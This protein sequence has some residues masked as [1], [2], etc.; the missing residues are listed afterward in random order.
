M[1]RFAI[2][3][4][5]LFCLAGISLAQSE[6]VSHSTVPAA[7]VSTTTPA[8]VA[9]DVAPAASSA[10]TTK[11]PKT[12]WWNR[13]T[14]AS[15]T[16]AKA[17]AGSDVRA[18]RMTRPGDEDRL[19]VADSLTPYNGP[20]LD[21]RAVTPVRTPPLRDIV[22]IPPPKLG[23]EEAGE[24]HREPMIPNPP[25]IKGGPD[26]F[27]QTAPGPLISAP[28]LTG[29]NF[30]GIGVGL[31]AFTPNSNPPDTNGRVG[32]TQYVQWNNTSFAVF[33]KTTGALLFGPV[34]GNT[35][36]QTLGGVCASHNDGD[37]TVAYDLLSGRWILAQFVVQAPAGTASHECVAISATSDATGSYYVY[38]FLTDPTNFVDYPKIGV[39]PDGYYMTGHVFNAA[40]TSLV[41]ARVYA[42]ERSQMIQGLPARQ[43]SADLPTNGG[44]VQYGFLPADLDSLTP[45]PAGEA[46]FIL[47]PGNLTNQTASTRVA[48]TWGATPTMTLTSA[49]ITTVGITVA[50]CVGSA[51]ARRCA[52]QP[53]PAVSTDAVDNLRSHYMYRLAYRNFGGSPVQE[54]LVVSATSQGTP[55]NHNAIKWMEFRNDGTST[56]TP[57]VFQSGTFD[58]DLTYRFMPSIAMDS[59]GDI[60]LGYSGSSTTVFPGIFA[61]GRL[62]TDPINTMGAETTVFAGVGVQIPGATAGNRWG[63]YSAMT[64]DPVDQCTFWYTNEYLPNNGAF[65]WS[66]RIASMSF[67]SCTPA[68][69]WGTISG[70]ITSCATGVP[71]SGVVV[72]LDNGFSGA[73]DAS[74]NYSILVPAG[75]YTAT[76]ADPSRDCA[77]STPVSSPLTASSGLTTT[78]N[79]CMTGT[80]NLQTN[81]MTLDDSSS[82]NNNGVVNA[83]ECVAVSVPLLNA[84][85]G[86]ETAIAATL[87]TTTTGVTVTQPTS[88]YPDI[89]I[90]Q[91]G[92]GT[93]PFR[94]Q[95]SPSFPCGTVINFTLDVTYA[96]GSKS[97]GFSVPTCTGGA[98]Q[99]IPSYPGL[100]ASDLTQNDRIGRTG[101]P[102]TC[103]GKA[104]PGG[105]FTG[106]HFYKPYTFTNPSSAPACFTVTINAAAG[107]AG[108]IESVAY[109]P[110]YDPNNIGTNYLGDT[111]ISGLGT[112]ITSGSYS[113]VV[114]ANSNFVVVMEGASVSTATSAFSG[115]VSGFID[116]TLGPGG[117]PGPTITPGGATTFCAG[118]SVTLSSSSATGNQWLVNGNPIGGETNQTYIAST[119]G[120]YSVVALSGGCATQPSSVTT[121]T[122]NPLP[123]TPTITPGGPTT[124][125]Y[126]GSVTLNSSSASRQPVVSRQRLR[127]Q[128]DRRCD[129]SGLRCFGCRQLHRDRHGR[130]R[131]CQRHIGDHDRHRQ[132]GHAGSDRNGRHVHV[133]RHAEGGKRL[134]PPVAPVRA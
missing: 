73:S 130:Q 107:G 16:A 36:F 78:Q 4:L 58:P 50:N 103:A 45:P 2:A 31:G 13:H 82:G 51:S 68:P 65:N 113:F 29:L 94:F 85:C 35:L 99:S 89:A 11:P 37:P 79:F 133:R 28:T 76:A 86:D 43:V 49:I 131:L 64:L 116:P 9:P 14:R 111:G 8:T 104:N 88:A 102:S 97:L 56:A 117:P 27:F 32:A 128:P 92:T 48:V 46:E 98:D 18:S 72:T 83:N 44:S 10:A 42:F 57:T 106:I 59:S 55:N 66:T 134:P 54:S 41:A 80:S 39:W 69:A 120:D 24:G 5:V 90:D 33:N 126:P 91:S 60:A 26:G 25:T 124:F 21:F 109:A 67:P 93:T 15:S 62:V 118:G 125:T 81:G 1:K 96:S 110:T 119:S 23:D 122:I 38:D 112:T 84:G 3:A 129:E 20:P 52:P 115:T 123:P 114:P 132:S 77:S 75:S 108:D 53:P 22:P 61:T 74:G 34:A 71:L 87:S 12:H 63:D 40:G 6:E 127:P 121:V 17:P 19:P 101:I 105:G 47:G 100:S 95:T 30:A 70:N 7:T